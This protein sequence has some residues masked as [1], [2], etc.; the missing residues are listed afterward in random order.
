MGAECEAWTS[1][2]MGLAGVSELDASAAREL[3]RDLKDALTAFASGRGSVESL[4]HQI[5]RIAR[6]VTG[7]PSVDLK[8]AGGRM[9]RLVR[10][11]VPGRINDTGL[12]GIGW[13][14]LYS[15]A[16]K[17]R[18]DL[19]HTGTA[20]ALVGTRVATMATVLLAALAEV[21]KEKG[22]GKVK[23]I[24]VSNPVFAHCWQTLADLRRTML[25]NDFSVLPLNNDDAK[26][27]KW[28]CVR[29][30]ELADFLAQGGNR[31]GCTLADA[32]SGESC[33]RMRVYCARI[34]CEDE[35]QGKLLGRDALN[36]PVVVGRT[37]E[38]R[39]E[40]VGIVTAFDLL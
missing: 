6:Y 18:N 3:R 8:K 33:T 4:L 9:K 28:R 11:F 30:E 2:E 35:E 21:A 12:P 29:A 27:R 36:L 22:V 16:V 13:E 10:R 25:V 19:A 14:D 39:C 34:V 17:G 1:Q 15:A 38:G 24:M 23:D 7:K 32:L 40:I 5:E 37:V 31:D 26:D 20:G